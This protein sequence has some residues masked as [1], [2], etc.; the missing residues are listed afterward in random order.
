[1]PQLTLGAALLSAT[2]MAAEPPVDADGPI[3]ADDDR[4]AAAVLGALGEQANE[5]K[6][7]NSWAKVIAGGA[8]TTAG[9]V[10]D[11][12]YDASYGPALWLGGVAVMANGLASLFVRPPIASFAAEM[13]PAPVGLEATWRARAA[14]AKSRRKLVGIIDLSVGAVGAGAATV[15]AAGVGDLSR[16]DRSRWVALTILAGG[17]AF[18]DGLYRL[19]VES[20]I[21]KGYGLAYPET[22]L[23]AT[24]VDVSIAPLP[25]GAALALQATF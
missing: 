18:A 4:R 6:T 19:L 7:V 23:A 5:F 12:R 17:V 20:D 13:G 11:S 24:R 8:F 25:R 14:D 16:E 2:A 22:T 10:V 21:E 3:R 15:L 9:I 1:M